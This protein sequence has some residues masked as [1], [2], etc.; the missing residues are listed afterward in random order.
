MGSPDH[1]K[2]WMSLNL[3]WL[4]EHPIQDILWLPGSHDAGINKVTSF[5]GTQVSSDNVQT[6]TTDIRGQ[7]ELG[8]R[9]FDIR[10]HRRDDG[11]WWCGHYGN[12]N[13]Y[14][15]SGGTGLKIEEVMDQASKFVSDYPELVVLRFTHVQSAVDGH[16]IEDENQQK[17][18]LK[19]IHSYPSIY[20]N[21]T[22]AINLMKKPLKD[23]IHAG[24]KTGKIIITTRRVDGP[25]IEGSHHMWQGNP[26]VGYLRGD[27]G[28]DESPTPIG[29][30]AEQKVADGILRS[31]DAQ[32]I[33][34]VLKFG[35]AGLPGIAF[36]LFSSNAKS[37][38]QGSKEYQE[39]ELPFTPQR[40]VTE[41][42]GI[43]MGDGICDDTLIT[44]CLAA[45]RARYIVK[46]NQDLGSKL[47]VAY[48]GRLIEDA[49]ALQR[50]RE[51]IGNYRD[52]QVN[53]GNLGGEPWETM[54]KS[55]VVFYG[56]QQRGERVFYRGRFAR[57]HGWL[58]F[59]I[60]IEK[61]HYHHTDLGGPPFAKAYYEIFR[62][63][64]DQGPF[65]PNLKTLGGWDPDPGKFKDVHIMYRSGSR[66]KD[67]LKE[68]KMRE[69]V[70]TDFGIEIDY[71]TWDRH[72][73]FRKAQTIKWPEGYRKFFGWLEAKGGEYSFKCHTDTLNDGHNDCDPAVGDHKFSTM[74]YRIQKDGRWREQKSQEGWDYF[75]KSA[76]WIEYEPKSHRHGPMG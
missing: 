50:V 33:A 59:N 24:D 20:K 16:N 4:G 34:S 11:S 13:V 49:G 60:D 43:V 7:L 46:E 75:V 21:Q 42:P 32:T 18:L 9:W 41:D 64:W 45:S 62:S 1:I 51:A 44:L 12:I 10:P 72:D 3:S 25:G 40:L 27:W 52:F 30:T 38:L 28:E 35:L 17:Q 14:G 69:H 63:L 6:Q 5:S 48:G 70:V 26:D 65:M 22:G 53:N 23:Y 2:K 29:L 39:S 54:H 68:R 56:F 57:E 37:I 71:I 61:I 76:S 15:W 58:S 19:L 73:D 66:S 74:V 31:A 67:A 55:C 8:A 47:V 36:S